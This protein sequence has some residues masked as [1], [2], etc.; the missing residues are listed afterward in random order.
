MIKQAKERGVK[1]ILLTPSP[2]QSVDYSNPNNELKKHTDQIRKIALENQV[3]LSDTYHAFEFLY[4]DKEKLS[5]YMAQVNHPNQLGH[6]L[7]ANEL[8]KWF[9]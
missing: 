7:I 4:P 1:V 8:M 2:D 3:G 5:K 6:E 9:K